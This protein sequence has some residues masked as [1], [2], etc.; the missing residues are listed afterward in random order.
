M[1]LGMKPGG[2]PTVANGGLKCR[3]DSRFI[4]TGEPVTIE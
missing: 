3:F 1:S 4:W 2:R